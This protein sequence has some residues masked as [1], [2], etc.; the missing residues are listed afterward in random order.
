M[1]NMIFFGLKRKLWNKKYVLKLMIIFIVLGGILYVDRIL[2]N[3]TLFQRVQVSL[4]ES[5]IMYKE[6]FKDT[7]NVEYVDKANIRIVFEDD[8]KIYSDEVISEEVMFDIQKSISKVPGYTYTEPLYDISYYHSRIKDP[9]LELIVY[10]MVYFILMSKSVGS[11]QEIIEDKHS[12]MA[13][14]YLTC[15]S[16][17]QYVV[18]KIVEGWIQVFIEYICMFVFICI[19]SLIRYGYPFTHQLY[20]WIQNFIVLD[21]SY[22]RLPI[23]LVGIVS[24]LIG[25]FMIQYV[26]VLF[27]SKSKSIEEANHMMIWIHSFPILI[28]YVAMSIYDTNV[29]NYCKYIPFLQ[30]LLLPMS[31]SLEG[32]ISLIYYGYM[33]LEGIFLYFLLRLSKNSM[34]KSI[35][36][37]EKSYVP[38]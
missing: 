30:T 37:I 27:M 13:S 20:D 29:I 6:Y 28:Y 12:G 23:L 15:I 9:Y 25:I 32:K 3:I 22:F 21:E 38:I 8:W 5:T 16:S 1:I 34:R 31:L 26:I 18:C 24:M 17:N 10:T 2:E 33:L 7:V 11:V 4:D 19:W 35:L 36:D 14:Y